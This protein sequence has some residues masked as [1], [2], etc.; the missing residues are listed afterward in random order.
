MTATRPRSRPQPSA[1]ASGSAD[2]EPAPYRSDYDR[3]S[4][5]FALLGA[6]E[7]QIAEA[8][9]ISESTLNGW[10]RDHPEFLASLRRGQEA[11]DAQVAESLFR[12]AIGCS[13][14]DFIISRNGGEVTLTETTKHYPPDTSAAIFWLKNRQRERWRELQRLEHTGKDGK[15]LEA[16]SASA[17]DL[18]AELLRRGAM[19]P[20]GTGVVPIKYV[21]KAK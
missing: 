18:H 5:Q 10:K 17:A 7:L 15:T 20:P 14:P 16:V 13:H 3:I 19:L 4:Y 12:R 2:G 6:S 9:G 8:L 1:F 21:V 11:A